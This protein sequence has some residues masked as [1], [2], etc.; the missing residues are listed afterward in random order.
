M[1]LKFA[2]PKLLEILTARMN[3]TLSSEAVTWPAFSVSE[4]RCRG[5]TQDDP[6][7]ARAPFVGRQLDG[8]SK[9]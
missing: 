7:N 3:N 8:S 1:S 5:Y 4:Y 6:P 2:P 9:A